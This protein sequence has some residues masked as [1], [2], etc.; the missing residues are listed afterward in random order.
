MCRQLQFSTIILAY[1][2]KLQ[3][4]QIRLICINIFSP[5][6]LAYILFNHLLIQIC[7][8]HDFHQLRFAL[9]F[10]CTIFC[11]LFLWVSI[12]SHKRTHTRKQA[13]FGY[14][15][16]LFCFDLQILLCNKSD[17]FSIPI[18][19]KIDLGGIEYQY[20]YCIHINV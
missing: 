5:Q 9:L 15:S 8:Y 16:R 7:N 6:Y 13:F 18:D 12:R 4:C 20:I 14:V 17:L 2:S 11:C 3:K 10:V 1:V 19:C